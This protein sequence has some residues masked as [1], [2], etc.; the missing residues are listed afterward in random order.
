[1]EGEKHMGDTYIDFRVVKERIPIQVVLDHYG[2]RLRRINQHSL[3][4]KCP[5]PTHTSEKSKESFCVDDGKNIWS[6]ASASCA[7]ARQGKRGGNI[8]DLTSIIETCS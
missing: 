4:G 1:M 5:L 2:I 8:L 7:A 6:C 3:R